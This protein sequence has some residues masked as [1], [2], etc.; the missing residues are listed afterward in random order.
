VE[1]TEGDI[2]FFLGLPEW[3]L[4]VNFLGEMRFLGSLEG[5][6]RHTAMFHITTVHIADGGPM[7]LC[8]P[9]ML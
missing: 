1:F 2:E 3:I 5:V 7:R 4:Q 8:H 6:H 9:E